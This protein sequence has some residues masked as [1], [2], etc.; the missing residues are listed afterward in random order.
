MKEI[1]ITLFK[2]NARIKL[3]ISV[4]KEWQIEGW[5]S[6]EDL[7]NEANERIE[8]AKLA[9]LKKLAEKDGVKNA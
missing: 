2:D 5:K 6:E 4:A 8:K 7:K 3:P 9:N 1:S